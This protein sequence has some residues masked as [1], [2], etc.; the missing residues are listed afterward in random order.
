MADNFGQLQNGRASNGGRFYAVP[1]VPVAANQIFMPSPATTPLFGVA[2]YSVS[3]NALGSFASEGVFVFDKPAGW[4]DDVGKKIFY[5]PTGSNSGAFVLQETKGDVLVGF[6][7]L[8]NVPANKLGVLLTSPEFV[9]NKILVTSTADSGP[10]SLRQAIADAQSG[11]TIVFDSSLEDSQT[12]VITIYLDTQLELT[13]RN[14][15]I[16]GGDTWTNNG[17]LKTRAVLDSQYDGV[18]AKRVLR[19]AY[20]GNVALHG[21]TFQ[22]GG[23][24]NYGG[25]FL[26]QTSGQSNFINDCVFYNGQAAQTGGGVAVIGSGTG[27]FNNCLFKNCNAGI[28]GGGISVTGNATIALNNCTFIGNTAVN[29]GAS[30]HFSNTSAEKSIVSCVIGA[31]TSANNVYISSTNTLITDIICDKLVFGTNSVATISGNLTA[32]VLTINNGASITFSGVDSI[33]TA[34]T[35]ASVGSATFT[36]A[37]DSTGYAAFPSGTDVSQATF[38][39]V[40]NCTYGAGL[41]MFTIDFEGATWTADDLTVP[42]LIEE[43]SGETWTTLD[44]AATGGTYAATFAYGDSV[45]G[46]DGVQFLEASLDAYW[47]VKSWG[48]PSNGGGSSGDSDPSWVVDSSTI[49]PNIEEL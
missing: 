11:D 6:Q 16:D 30:V 24:T 3:A 20:S 34:T 18:N 7:V 35:T 2:E 46:F 27:T 10:G 13:T 33:L 37:A 23:G 4:I 12:G 29:Y 14:V 25:C 15:V 9:V 40:K 32:D 26:L 28:Q 17:E 45:R 47:K 19:T 8:A 48:V 42:I 38:T 44:A 1:S 21:L 22:N 43:K 5:R 49:T 36:A 41:E 31:T 39:G